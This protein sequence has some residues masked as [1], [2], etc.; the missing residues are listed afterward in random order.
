M[1]NIQT[2]DKKQ[3]NGVVANKTS[4]SEQQKETKG[5]RQ[6]REKIEEPNYSDSEQQGED[7]TYNFRS[8]RAEY[9]DKN[10]N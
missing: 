6:R 1:T 9:K 3:E 7:N 4:N 5:D 8:T 2:K 10:R